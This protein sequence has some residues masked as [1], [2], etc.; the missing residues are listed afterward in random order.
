MVVSLLRL[1][2]K[3]VL[4]STK[5][6][7]TESYSIPEELNATD[8]LNILHNHTLLADTFWPQSESEVVEEKRI[9]SSTT[10]FVISSSAGSARATMSKTTDGL[11]YQEEMPLGLKMAIYYKVV[12][13]QDQDQKATQAS[14]RPTSSADAGLYLVEERSVAAPRPLSM[15]VKVK[16]GPIEKTRHLVW[17]LNEL[18][19]NG[20][21]MAEALAG[22]RASAKDLDGMNGQA[23]PKAD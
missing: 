15:I 9:S 13:V 3:K 19:W 6:A 5:S 17:L 22:L 2:L 21:N 23:K 1:T 16:E 20:K 11:F 14:T 12:D 8:V 10:E 18:G 7:K 4:Y